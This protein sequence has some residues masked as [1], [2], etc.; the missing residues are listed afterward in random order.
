MALNPKKYLDLTGTTYLWGKIK[1]YV[2]G[3]VV[4]IPASNLTIADENNKFTS[5]TVE[6]ALAELVDIVNAGGTGSVITVETSE[7]GN[8][9]AK[10]Y[11]FKQ[12]G[13]AISN[14]TID[15]PADMVVSSGAVK[16]ATV[17]TPLNGET[18]G[19]YIELTLANATQDKLYI[20]VS[21]LIEYV[22]AGSAADDAVQIVINDQHQVSASLKD[23]SIGKGKLDTGVQASLGKADSAM[24]S[25]SICG[26]TLGDGGTLTAE[27]IKTAIGLSDAV[28]GVVGNAA[29][30]TADSKTIEGTRKYAEAQAQA[31]YDAMV[32]ITNAEIDNI[33]NPAP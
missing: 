12:G 24:Q 28:S 1:A 10:R 27:Q 19:T 2:D 22:S 15:I 8:G 11:T 29:T 30:D 18:S 26:E 31:V 23:G 13:T 3:K 33:V 25:V 16:T 32:A 5:T 9:I 6:G 7:P 17:D 14:G 20:D 21:S 4:N